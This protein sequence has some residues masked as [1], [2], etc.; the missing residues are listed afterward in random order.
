MGVVN[1]TEH[2]GK[3]LVRNRMEREYSGQ[4]VTGNL[5]RTGKGS[6]RTIG[7]WRP[8]GSFLLGCNC[9]LHFGAIL[10][11]VIDF[12]RPTGKY[13]YIRKMKLSKFLTKT[14]GRMESAPILT[15]TTS[16]IFTTFFRSTKS[17]D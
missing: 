7:K 2:F 16:L 12:Q 1:S 17:I 11:D 13:W 15:K 10:F 6:S 8:I 5:G 4:E 14:S 3:K 9:C